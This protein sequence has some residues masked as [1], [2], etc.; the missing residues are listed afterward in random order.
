MTSRGLVGARARCD[1]ASGRSAGHAAVSETRRS[2][3]SRFFFVTSRDILRCESEQIQ[4][5]ATEAKRST[6]VWQF[7]N[8][9]HSDA[10]W[11]RGRNDA[12]AA[13]GAL[14]QTALRSDPCQRSSVRTMVPGQLFRRF[15]FWLEEKVL[16]KKVGVPCDARRHVAPQV[17]THAASRTR[18]MDGP[19]D[20]EKLPVTVRAVGVISTLADRVVERRSLRP[21][22]DRAAAVASIFLFSNPFCGV[23]SDRSRGCSGTTATATPDAVPHRD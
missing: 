23:P 5:C 3:F 11:F 8:L 16:V 4:P 9:V 7:R 18:T 19:T 22:D 21:R 6:A 20:A 17:L 10:V 2:V 14:L 15:F 1:E 12:R 13:K